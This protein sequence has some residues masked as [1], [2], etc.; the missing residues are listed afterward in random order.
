VERR[1][2]KDEG[3]W[4]PQC[5]PVQRRTDAARVTVKSAWDWYLEATAIIDSEREREVI[6]NS[7]TILIFVS[8]PGRSLV[9]SL[10]PP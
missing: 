7:D 9:A 2:L 5:F 8:T 6:E 1:K 4:I 3:E 10:T